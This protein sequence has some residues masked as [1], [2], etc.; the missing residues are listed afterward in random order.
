MAVLCLCAVGFVAPALGQWSAVAQ[1]P[2]TGKGKSKARYLRHADP[3]L[4][5]DLDEDEREEQGGGS[6]RRRTEDEVGGDSGGENEATVSALAGREPSLG[7]GLC[8][9]L[10]I[11]GLES[12][13]DW[14][15]ENVVSGLL[16]TKREML[17]RVVRVLEDPESSGPGGD[18]DRPLLLVQELAVDETDAAVGSGSPVYVGKATDAGGWS[19]ELGGMNRWL[20]RY[21]RE[22]LDSA[23]PVLIHVH[24]S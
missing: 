6:G 23:R 13:S 22:V 10:H 7:G 3:V 12:C 24:V 19:P 9:P 4:R 16:G 15:G 21:Y 11:T 5:R 1:L 2:A 17:R 18:P 20:E 14:R 8:S